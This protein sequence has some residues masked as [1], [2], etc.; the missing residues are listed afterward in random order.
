MSGFIKR[1]VQDCVTLQQLAQSRSASCTTLM[2]SCIE[3]AVA[4]EQ[5]GRIM[6]YVQNQ[7]SERK[8]HFLLRR[9]EERLNQILNV[10][11]TD[12]YQ[13]AYDV[14][15]AD[16]QDLQK[17]D[18]ELVQARAKYQHDSIEY[19][20]IIRQD[21]NRRSGKYMNEPQIDCQQEILNLRSEFQTSREHFESVCEKRME[22]DEALRQ[23]LRRCARLPG[24][25]YTGKHSIYTLFD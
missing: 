3:P 15:R 9:K 18:R 13:A 21:H 22:V 2:R 17:V 19:R 16:L 14:L 7:I 23:S 25:I 20:E 4:K 10:H 6:G 5:L 8:A 12:S 24:S 11:E 1:F